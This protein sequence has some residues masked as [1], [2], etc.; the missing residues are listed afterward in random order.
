LAS[1]YNENGKQLC[2][3]VFGSMLQCVGIAY[4]ARG[5]RSLE[6]WYTLDPIYLTDEA[7]FV[8]LITKWA[9]S[10]TRWE[11]AFTL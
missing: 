7:A 2:T 8:F 9:T 6:Y 1:Y 10:G 11:Q 5:L 4:Q 3:Q